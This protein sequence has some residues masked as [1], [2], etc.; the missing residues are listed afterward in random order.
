LTH[1]P[2]HIIVACYCN[3]CIKYSTFPRQMKS[4]ILAWSF[5]MLMMDLAI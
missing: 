5:I 4:C 1:R 2:H 3:K